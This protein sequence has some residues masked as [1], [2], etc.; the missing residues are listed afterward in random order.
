[1]KSTTRNL[2]ALMGALFLGVVGCGEDL[3][4]AQDDADETPEVA[5][6]QAD[7]FALPPGA[8]V[9]KH[10]DILVLTD[11]TLNA[12]KTYQSHEQFV[13]AAASLNGCPPFADHGTY[14]LTRRGSHRFITLK[15]AITQDRTKY[16]YSVHFVLPAGTS[17]IVAMKNLGTQAEFAL[18]PATCEDLGGQCK[19]STLDV[20][21]PANCEQ[22]L[23]MRT[24]AGSC[25]AITQACCGK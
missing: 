12:D 5:A 22:E 7:G 18:Q 4:A 14:T 24:L 20:T 9:N 8:Y 3:T 11:L 16:E 15:S 19:S 2:V 10:V 1:M 23:G 25:A 17:E 21:F 6:D 13:C